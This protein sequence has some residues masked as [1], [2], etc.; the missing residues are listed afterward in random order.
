MKQWIVA[1]DGRAYLHT[2]SPM[3]YLGKGIKAVSIYPLGN[4][5]R[6]IKKVANQLSQ[7]GE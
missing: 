4:D 1:K 3:E 2:E 7:K 6:L 5:I